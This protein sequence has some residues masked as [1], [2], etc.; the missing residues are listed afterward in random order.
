MNFENPFLD[1]KCSKF[2]H[3][4]LVAEVA[5]SI[6]IIGDYNGKDLMKQIEEVKDLIAT[7]IRIWIQ[8]KLG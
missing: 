3:G 7:I 5:M 8:L 4:T 6:Q 1:T 2:I